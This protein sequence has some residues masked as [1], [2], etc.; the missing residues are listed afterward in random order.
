MNSNDR[1]LRRTLGNHVEV[2]R[3]IL[4]KAT[5]ENRQ[6]T[7]E[8]AST[9]NKL[10]TEIA[11]I[12]EK[13]DMRHEPLS[14]YETASQFGGN[15]RFAT[16]PFSKHVSELETRMALRMMWTQARAW[17][18]TQHDPFFGLVLPER[19]LL[20]ERFLSLD[21]MKRLIEAA[22]EPYKTYYWIFAETGLRARAASVAM[23]IRRGYFS[24]EPLN[25]SFN[26]CRVA[27]PMPP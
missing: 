15:H 23:R 16:E 10:D 13:L 25:A 14:V 12:A 1:E 26:S 11:S 18:Y 9:F 7:E 8:E 2:M 19:V 5:T 6:L 27:S 17:G 4:N 20:N 24:G 22:P 21:E 3:G